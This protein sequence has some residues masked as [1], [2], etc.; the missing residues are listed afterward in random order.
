MVEMKK[1]RLHLVRLQRNAGTRWLRQDAA[2][3]K[4]RLLDGP[5]QP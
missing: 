3:G 4:R 2:C 1:W 5:A